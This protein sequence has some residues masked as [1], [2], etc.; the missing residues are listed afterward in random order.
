MGILQQ[1]M[2]EY[3]E[4]F[5]DGDP[6]VFLMPTATAPKKGQAAEL[7]CSV[8]GIPIFDYE[9]DGYGRPLVSN[10]PETA[11]IVLPPPPKKHVGVVTA[12]N[13]REGLAV[14]CF[15]DHNEDVVLQ[16]SLWH[17][18]VKFTDGTQ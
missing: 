6:T 11:A 15:G 17:T 16:K 18:A 13:Y 1:E 14:V 7:L 9:F 10:T 5:A 8:Y 3:F 12:V 2:Q 4:Q